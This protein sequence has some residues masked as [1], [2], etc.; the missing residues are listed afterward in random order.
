ME[1]TETTVRPRWMKRR[2][3]LALLPEHL[4]KCAPRKRHENGPVDFNY[5]GFQVHIIGY[6]SNYIGS[7]ER[8]DGSLFWVKKY[9]GS[10]FVRR[11]TARQTCKTVIKWHLRFGGWVLPN[12]QN[13]I[14][15]ALSEPQ[16]PKVR[17][18]TLTN[19]RRVRS[20]CRTVSSP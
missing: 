13:A 16:R 10:P 14:S 8:E 2:E 18:P 6:Y 9:S 7:I 3:L 4:K 5:Q 12:E 19:G 15:Q 1:T 20:G 17:K 11:K